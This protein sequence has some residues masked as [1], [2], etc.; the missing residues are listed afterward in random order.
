[1]K[2]IY[3]VLLTLLVIVMF[4]IVMWLNII[5]ADLNEKVKEYVRL[6]DEEDE[7]TDRDKQRRSD[8]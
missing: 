8:I 3:I 2:T 7:D 1:M 6:S 4:V 5:I